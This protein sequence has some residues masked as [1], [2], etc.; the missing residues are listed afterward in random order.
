MLHSCVSSYRTKIKHHHRHGRTSSWNCTWDGIRK[1]NCPHYDLSPRMTSTSIAQNAE[2]SWPCERRQAASRA[3]G[4]SAP[5][6]NDERRQ[7]QSNW[8][9]QGRNAGA[10]RRVRFM[11]N[12]YAF[13]IRRMPNRN[14]RSNWAVDRKSNRE[15]FNR[16]EHEPRL[17][18]F[19]EL[20]PPYYYFPQSQ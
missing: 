15:I 12:T 1:M 17:T 3:T 14:R 18:N 11:R 6:A 9:N 4:C 10:D 16:S 8:D 13:H 7:A 19:R 2:A 20:S 5:S